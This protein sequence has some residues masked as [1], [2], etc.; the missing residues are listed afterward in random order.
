MGVMGID[1]FGWIL[2]GVGGR[3]MVGLVAGWSGDSIDWISAIAR[4]RPHHHGRGGR[5]GTGVK[6]FVV[7]LIGTNAT[8]LGRDKKS[9]TRGSDAT[10]PIV[11]GG[12]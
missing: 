2:R 4:G 8:V 9:G 7:V 3:G 10:H 1:G 5:G 11:M 6:V 12:G